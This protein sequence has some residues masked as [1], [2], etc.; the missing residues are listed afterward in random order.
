FL[1]ASERLDPEEIRAAQHRKLKQTVAKAG[2]DSPFYRKLWERGGPSSRYR[3]LAGIPVITKEDL[4]KSDGAFPVAGYPG[5]VIVSRT[6]GSTGSP[7]IFYRSLEQESWFWA[8]RM[9]IWG[10]AGYR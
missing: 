6:S 1:Q 7:M 5:R 8:L 2:A 10:W 9:R 4:R 3:P